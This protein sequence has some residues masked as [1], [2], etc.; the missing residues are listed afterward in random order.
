MSS[1]GGFSVRSVYKMKNI[2]ADYRQNIPTYWYYTMV[3][4]HDK[5]YA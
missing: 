3:D 5:R 4:K 1:L 2:V